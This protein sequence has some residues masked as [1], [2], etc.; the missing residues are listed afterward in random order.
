MSSPASSR[1]V[2][3]RHVI[4]H[5]CGFLRLRELS[6]IVSVAHEWQAAVGSMRSIQA[7]ERQP[8]DERLRCIAQSRLARHIG[9]IG[10]QQ[11]P[12][13]IA[14]EQITRL[15][16]RF[17]HVTEM[18]ASC[19]VDPLKATPPMQF[20]PLLRTLQLWLP[21]YNE[22]LLVLGPREVSALNSALRSFAQHAPRSLQSL[23]LVLPDHDANLDVSCIE[24]LG[25]PALRI[26]YMIHQDGYGRF[27]I[28]PKPEPTPPFP[29]AER[30][31]CIEVT[32]LCDAHRLVLFVKPL[33]G[34]AFTIPW[35]RWECWAWIKLRVF[36]ACG[37]P[38]DRQRL[39]FAGAQREDFTRHS[40]LQ[41]QS[42]IHLVIREPVGAV[43]QPPAQAAVAPAAM[44]PALA[45]AP[46][47]PAVVPAPRRSCVVQ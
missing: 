6:R 14:G 28:G 1:P 35:P 34:A 10:E 39:I 8:H 11:A 16:A 15:A 33:N 36:E 20:P 22:K 31:D 21:L 24:A 3:Y 2:L 37:V 29:C 30:A 7:H 17:S 9:V 32:R 43:A 41:Y 38:P 23:T 5:I 42:T 45:P 25:I 46:L 19:T 26:S 13:N 12:I 27:I 4:E 18:H 40:G 47:P 44:A